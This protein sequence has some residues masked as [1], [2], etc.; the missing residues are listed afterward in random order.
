ML[1]RTPLYGE[2]KKLGA[3]LVEFGGWEMPVQYSGVMKEHR[4]VRKTCGLF[5]ISHMG[6][7]LITGPKALEQVNY[8]TTNDVSKIPDGKCQY[9][10]AL[11]PD[12]GVVD[13]LIVY[14]MNAEKFLIVVN[15][16]NDEKDFNWFV[17]NNRFDAQ[18][19][20]VSD[21]YGMLALQGP[22]ACD[23]LASLGGALMTTT[24]NPFSFVEEKLMGIPCIISHTGYTG[25][26]GFEFLVPSDKTVF[27]WNKIIEVGRPFGLFP[28]GLGARD[29]LRLEAA[30]SLYGHEIDQNINPLEARLSWIVKLDKPDFIGKSSLQKI[31]QE[32]IKRH[33]VGLSMIDAGIPR[34]GYEVYEG[35]QKLGFITSGTFSP[36][37]GK[38]IALALVEGTKKP[39]DEL[40]VG[41]RKQK[42]RAQIINLPFYV[43]R[44]EKYGNSTRS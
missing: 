7:V 12:G 37:L 24:L 17:Q 36:S 11:Y 19:S 44:K 13:D 38:A 4:V 34:A 22:K 39:G 23:V 42:V 27:L 32:G 10:A 41:I 35:E 1:K 26:D 30:L 28:I 16:S 8:L 5:D 15:A 20:H 6:Q 31:A 3:R 43:R 2:H 29:T 21:A 40:L 9:T 14:R 33:L 18:I 25:E